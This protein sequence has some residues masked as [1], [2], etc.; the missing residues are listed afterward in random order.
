MIKL[1]H[2]RDGYTLS[3]RFGLLPGI[4]RPA[5]RLRKSIA[6]IDCMPRRILG[7]ATA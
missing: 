3:E 5:S 2:G 1:T 4:G 6:T 7:V